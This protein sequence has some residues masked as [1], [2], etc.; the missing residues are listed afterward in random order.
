[1]KTWLVFIVLT[2][3]VPA[4]FAEKIIPSAADTVIATWPVSRSTEVQEAQRTIR[5]RPADTAAVV[6]LAN[7]Y[8]R[9]AALPGQSRLYGVAQAA[10]KPLIDQGSE[11]PDVWLA[12]A[13]VQQHQHAFTEALVALDKVKQ[14]EPNNT[15]AHLLV[16]R[17]SLIQDNAEAARSA[18]LQLLGNADL[19]TASACA[20]E[21]NSLQGNLAQSYQ[22]LTTL[23]EREG[24]PA[25]ERGP[26]VAQILADM[27]ARL[28]NFGAAETWLNTQRLD[29]A[30]VN[31]LGQWA[32]VQLALNQPGQLI[33]ALQPIVDAAADVDDALLLRLAL[34]EKA[35]GGDRW[36][37]QLSARIQLREQREDNQH[38]SEIARYYLDINPHPQRALHWANINWQNAREHSDK[39]LLERAMA[40]AA[41]KS[42]ENQHKDNH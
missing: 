39:T 38:A 11:R 3:A 4:S 18:C 10:L 28:Q 16:A 36:Q 25:D 5:V 31:F 1:M 12:W 24:L 41:N 21:V 20:L 40:N 14:Q 19:L 17:I 15:N 35:L 8:L 23:V 29:S 6:Q 30:S 33:Q 37:N 27:A 9:D 34:A 42:Q 7:A 13:Q 2:F 22:Q 26:W 32:D